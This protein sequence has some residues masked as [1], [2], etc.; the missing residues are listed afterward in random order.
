MFAVAHLEFLSNAKLQF[1]AHSTSDNTDRFWPRSF[2]GFGYNIMDWYLVM[3]R[4]KKNEM[5][6]VKNYCL[7]MFICKFL[8][9][10]LYNIEVPKVWSTDQ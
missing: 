4:M 2:N 10:P 8:A 9:G 7:R 6:F 1:K 3:T 5:F